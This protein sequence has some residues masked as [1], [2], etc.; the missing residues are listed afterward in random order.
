[1]SPEVVLKGSLR[2]KKDLSL[3]NQTMSSCRISKEPV[4]PHEQNHLNKR[5]RSG[6]SGDLTQSYHFLSTIE[7]I[8]NIEENR[9]KTS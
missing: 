4:N 5:R 3:L 2:A 7:I 6:G 8:L 1:M 9:R